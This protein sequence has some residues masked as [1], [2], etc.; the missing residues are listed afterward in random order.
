[1]TTDATS[2]NAGAGTRFRA[3]LAANHPLPI[4]GTINPYCAMMAER[5]GHKAIYLAGG[6]LATHSYGLPDL[7]ITNLTD[8]L[9]EVR[10]LTDA[11]SLPLL[12]DVD[13]GFGG[14]FSIARLVKGLIKDGA[15]AMHI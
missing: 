15:A 1:M 9:T 3:A 13:T 6:G 4:V 14:V 10:R 11:S 7:A 5:V 2:T 12:V 8:V